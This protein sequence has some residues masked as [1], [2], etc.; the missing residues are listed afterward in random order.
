MRAVLAAVAAM[1]GVVLGATPAAADGAAAGADLQVAQTLGDRELTVI[2]RRVDTP[3]A[4]LRVDVVTHAGTPAGRLELRVGTAGEIVGTTAVELGATPGFHT[5]ALRVDRAGP[6]QLAVDDGAQVATIPFVVPAGVASPWENATYGGF[7]VAGALLLAALGLAVSGR[8]GLAVVSAGGMVAALAVAV[9]AAV[10]APVIPAP[11]APG[12]QLDPTFDNVNDPYQRP[13]TTDQAAGFT[14]PPVS[15][16]T[17]MV[18]EDLR[19]QVTD[20]ATGR[21]VDDL[22][23]HHNAFVHLVVVAPSGAMAHLHPVRVAPGDYRARLNPAETGVHAVAAELARRGGGS[24]LVR[25]TVHVTA[26]TAAPQRK[27]APGPGTV[28]APVQP[29]GTPTTVTASFGAA[30][31]QPWLGMLGH[32]IVVGPVDHPSAAAGAPIWAHVHAML[33]RTPGFSEQ[34][35]ESV[36]TF[37][38]DVRFTYTFP[39][40]GRYFAWVQAQRD[41][42]VLTVPTVIDVPAPKGTPG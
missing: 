36:A 10:L 9:T 32:L 5:A 20:G 15:V 29:A 31:L 40:P 17:S 24:Q 28:R 22:V 35:D 14:R 26:E 4:P 25:S 21:P 38:P 41:Y 39:L 3:P 33:P 19:L 6:W 42:T 37:G 8:V 27:T 30:D 11:P 23:V 13:S 1:F 2:I 16:V 18:G 12:A 34:P 7:V